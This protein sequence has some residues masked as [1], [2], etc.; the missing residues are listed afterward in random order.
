METE[1]LS[2]PKIRMQMF[3]DCQQNWPNRASIEDSEYFS[4]FSIL[5]MFEKAAEFELKVQ[6]NFNLNNLAIFCNKDN[7]TMHAAYIGNDEVIYC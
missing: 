6:A 2:I 1:N 3:V 7:G 4:L 5:Q